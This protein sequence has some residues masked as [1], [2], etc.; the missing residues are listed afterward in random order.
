[1]ILNSPFITGS[2]TVTNNIVT[3]GSLTVLGTINGAVTGS[4]DSA[5]Y[6][7][8]AAVANSASFASNATSSS[9]ASTAT[10]ASQASNANTATSASFA[11]TATSASQASNANTATSASQAA[12]AVTSSYAANADLLDGKNST[13]FAITGSNTFTG[14]Q[15]VNATNNAISFTSTAS[16]YTDGGLRVTKD[17]YVSG[18]IYVNNLT[19]FGTQSINYITSSQL[20]IGTNIITVNTDVPAIR[21]GGLAVYDSGSTRLTGSLLWDSEDNHWVYSNPS[22]SSYDGGMMLSGPRNSS[23]LGNEQGTLSN[24]ILK[25]QGGDHVTSSLITENGTATT[26]YTNALYVSS[27]NLVG[28]GTTSPSYLFD[29]LSSNVSTARFRDSSRFALVTIESSGTNQSSYLEFKPTGTGTSIFQVNGSDRM[30]ITTGGNVGIGTTNPVGGGGASDRTLSINAATGAATFVTGLINGTRY[31]TLFTAANSVVLETNAAIPLAFNTN[32][33]ERM[34]IDSSG[35]V[36]VGT[37]SPLNKLQ[38]RDGNLGIYITQ[39]T[40]GALGGQIYLGDTNFDNSSYFNSAPGIGA[41]YNGSQAVNGDLALYAYASTANSRTERMRIQGNTGNIG[42]GT[43][44]PANRL[45]I[46]NDGN[47]VIAFR[48]NDINANASFLSLNASNSDAAILAGGTSAIP[49]DIYTG[50]SPRMRITAGGNVLIGTTSD[51]NNKLQVTGTGAYFKGTSVYNTLQI[52][53]SSTS[54]GGGM[55]FLQNGSIYGGIG[56]S[57][58]YLGGTSNNLYVVSELGKDILLATNGGSERMRIA[59]GGAI[60]LGAVGSV[61]GNIVNIISSGTTLYTSYRYSGTIDVGY[62]GNGPG[63]VAGGANGDFGIRA[64]NNLLFAIGNTERMRIN[65]SGNVGIGVS[66]QTAKLQVR[67]NNQAAVV[68][69]TG[70]QNYIMLGKCIQSYGGTTNTALLSFSVSG[71]TG[72]MFKIVIRGTNAVANQ[73]YE[74]V[75]YASWYCIGG[76]YQNSTLVQPSTV[77]NIA[78]SHNL[79]TLSW[80]NVSTAPVLRYS[81]ANNGYI[82]EAIDIY[83]TARDGGTIVFN[84]DYVNAG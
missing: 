40:G 34:R 72:Y 56:V 55:Y 48:I 73:A 53:N 63:L 75:A 82:L 43:T 32:S 74:D 12:N 64:E 78:G 27:S 41:A 62:I 35:N 42:I 2:I 79:G 38:V 10:S 16:I 20:N 67:S 80:G 17:A 22:G 1:M 37:T 30:A 54:G 68:F 13:E 52:D 76:G 84:V 81:Q 47:S 70:D 51:N 14:T 61:N 83:V 23:G 60:S 15:Y 44:N 58:W 11:L 18:T 28:I 26:F 46:S 77:I 29:V 59:S 66:N 49:F 19:V 7:A 4:V 3:S 71:N 33:T 57:G 9:F 39:G 25:G 36:G 24:V 65:S 31:S 50:G 6:A 69:Q 21:F 5:S 8:Y 45:T